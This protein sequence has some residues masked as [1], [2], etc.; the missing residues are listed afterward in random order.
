MAYSAIFEHTEK[1][2]HRYLNHS[3]GHKEF[4]VNSLLSDLNELNDHNDQNH[5]N[6]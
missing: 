4:N 5:L 1:N 2:N 3:N 6:L